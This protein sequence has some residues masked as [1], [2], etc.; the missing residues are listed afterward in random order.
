MIALPLWATVALWVAVVVPG[1]FAIVAT[2]SAA[3]RQEIKWGRAVR[4]A[5]RRR[6][7]FDYTP[8]QSPTFGTLEWQGTHTTTRQ[9]K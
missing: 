8:T 5:R 7:H 2:V 9:E 1:A 4:E 3:I 6:L